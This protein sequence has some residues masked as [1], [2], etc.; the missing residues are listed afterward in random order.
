MTQISLAESGEFPPR[1]CRSRAAEEKLSAEPDLGLYS[2]V[3]HDA[4]IV[5][6]DEILGVQLRESVVDNAV[7]QTQGNLFFV[8]VGAWARLPLPDR[9]ICL[10]GEVPFGSVIVN[11]VARSDDEWF[12]IEGG[13][14]FPID[15]PCCAICNTHHGVYSVTS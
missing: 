4:F 7:N 2:H 6:V 3:P 12:T 1:I 10:S 5:A 13:K 14:R 11:S 8:R 9:F 15:A